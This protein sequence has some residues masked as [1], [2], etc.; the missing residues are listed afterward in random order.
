L[1]EC[2]FRAELWTPL[3]ET[4][5]EEIEK[6]LAELPNLERS[7][8]LEL[9]VENFGRKPAA[10]TR[11]ELLVPI[12]AYRI[13]ERA[14]G[15]LKPETLA[16][17]RKIALALEKNPKAKILDNSGLNHG[18]RISRTWR[19][20]THEVTVSSGWFEYRGKTYKNLSEIAR[21]IT[22][23]R[24]SGPKFFGMRERSVESRQVEL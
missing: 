16:R 1:T 11:R 24:W 7:K 22:G 13:Q 19:G 5:V 4:P 15:G 21:L 10:G 20:V 3:E 14:Y 9:W 17:L 23:T 18:T 2:S 6:R 12:L 8:L